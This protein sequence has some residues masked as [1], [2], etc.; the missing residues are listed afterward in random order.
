MFYYFFFFSSRR[1]HT[2]YWRDWSSDVCSSDLVARYLEE[3]AAVG[4]TFIALSSGVQEKRPEAEARRHTFAVA[5]GHAQ[6]LQQRF[7]LGIHLDIT[8][9]SKVVAGNKTCQM[10]AQILFKRAVGRT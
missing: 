6:G 4:A 10:S 5:H 8:Q 2:R 7:M 3:Y 9:H 1:R